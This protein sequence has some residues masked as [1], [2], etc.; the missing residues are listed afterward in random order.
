MSTP[1]STDFQSTSENS[2]TAITKM[3]NH[4]V[5]PTPENYHLW[6]TYAASY[7]L[8]LSKTVD[9]LIAENVSFDDE[10]SKKLYNKFFS[11]NDENK[12]I[13]ETGESFKSEMAKIINILKEAS[14]STSDHSNNLATQM[15][16]LS[17]F[18]GSDDLKEIVK[19][20]LNDVDKINAQSKKLEMQLEE[21]SSKIEGLQSNLESARIESRTDALT[22]I[23][24]RKYFDEKLSELIASAK[25]GESDFCLIISDIDF[26]KKFN[27]LKQI[28]LITTHLGHIYRPNYHKDFS[29]PKAMQRVIG[30]I[31]LSATVGLVSFQAFLHVL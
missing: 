9:R 14:N 3:S 2:N 11:K 6:F 15:D 12:A 4:Q 23:G 16:N 18:E 29:M 28:D 13:S 21:S 30:F 7:D 5:S 26:F 24:N 20:V 10:I 25:E 17:D 8:T 1:P 22:K 19:L 27:D 31:L